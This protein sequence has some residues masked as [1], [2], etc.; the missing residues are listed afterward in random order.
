MLR[1]QNCPKQS[2]VTLSYAL[3]PK[4]LALRRSV[5]QRATS[6]QQPSI[7]QNS[8]ERLLSKRASCSILDYRRL[9]LPE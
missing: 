5:V 9:Q 6:E 7:N 1:M 8:T 4:G 2:C 3:C